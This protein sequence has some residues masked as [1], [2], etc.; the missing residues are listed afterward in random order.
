MTKFGPN[1]Q[2]NVSKSMRAI[3]LAALVFTGGAG[4]GVIAGKFPS[5]EAETQTETINRITTDLSAIRKE[6][7]E[8]KQIQKIQG[9]KNDQLEERLFRTEFKLR[10]KDFDKGR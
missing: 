9:D 6:L 4:G 7:Y 1:E 3:T 5:A 8:L 10:L 2:S